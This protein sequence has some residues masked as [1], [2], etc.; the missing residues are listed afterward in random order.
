MVVLLDVVV[1]ARI[2][3]FARISGFVD[4]SVQVDVPFYI[5][6]MSR[7]VFNPDVVRN[8]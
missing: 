5:Q 1:H 4:V 8:P 3:D 6:D 7:L 2:S